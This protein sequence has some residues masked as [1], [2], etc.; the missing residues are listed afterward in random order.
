LDQDFTTDAAQLL[1]EWLSEQHILEDIFGANVHPELMRRASSLLQL[2]ASHDKIDSSLLD[3]IAR[4][5]L[6]AHESIAE[7]AL[8]CLREAL[9]KCNQPVLNE[10]LTQ[11]QVQV[12]KGMTVPT[13][14]LLTTAIYANLVSQPNRAS[15]ALQLVFA[16]LLELEPQHACQELEDAV[17][18]QFDIM[19]RLAA[20]EQLS[21]PT[22]A[23]FFTPQFLHNK[24]CLRAV[25][26]LLYTMTICQSRRP[27]DLLPSVLEKE[28]VGDALVDVLLT[29]PDE[30]LADF[31]ALL[32]IVIRCG[33]SQQQT[34]LR[35]V[36]RYV[37]TCLQPQGPFT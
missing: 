37:H 30:L 34:L 28:R 23:P 22:L 25:T 20:L 14:Q 15:E 2:Q 35:C 10:F 31:L 13:V 24:H 29:A 19:T 21:I 12:R 8:E 5:V 6:E 1:S 11:A 32:M 3:T 17:H 33:P 36:P 7:V 27:T 18:H 16:L 9:V 26:T 4:L